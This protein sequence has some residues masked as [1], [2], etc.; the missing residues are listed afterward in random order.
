MTAKRLDMT[1]PALMG[2]LL[3][4]LGGIVLV[5]RGATSHRPS[6]RRRCFMAAMGLAL[7]TLVLAISLQG[8]GGFDLITDKVW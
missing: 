4:P 8:T 1:S 2:L 7:L 6:H 3:P 5:I